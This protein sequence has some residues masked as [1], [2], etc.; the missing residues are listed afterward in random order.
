MERIVLAYSGGLDTSVAI[1]WMAENTMRDH[2]GDDGPRAEAKS[3]EEVRE[4]ARRDRCDPR[5]RAGS[6]RRGLRGTTCCRP[7]DGRRDLRRPLYPMA[8]SLGRPLHR[9]QKLVEI[10][11]GRKRR[12]RSRT[13]ALERATTRSGWM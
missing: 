7:L 5:A 3:S 8:T 11:R 1:P 4:R 12:P 10:A 13:A 9:A 6:A 2:R